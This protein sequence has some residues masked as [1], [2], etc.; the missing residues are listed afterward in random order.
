MTALRK[1][2]GVEVAPK[3]GAGAALM[4]DDEA[5]KENVTI[6][7]AADAVA[8]VANYKPPI[9]TSENEKALK[10]VSVLGESMVA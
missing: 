8:V 4:E 6:V 10:A 2:A 9:T 3:P 7:V 1:R 5:V